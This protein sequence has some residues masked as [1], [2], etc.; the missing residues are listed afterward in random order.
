MKLRI[1]IASLIF[2]FPAMLSA[3]SPVISGIVKESGETGQPIAGANVYWAG[4]QTGTSTDAEGKFQLSKPEQYKLLVISF[5]G[6]KT[7]TVKVAPGL[8]NL[9]IE[10][11][12][13]LELGEVTVKERRKGIYYS[14]LNP[15]QV[16]KITTSELQ[17][18]AC[19]N[20]SESF[21]T[22]ASVDVAY[23]DAVTG[24]KQIQML[25]LAGTYVQTLGEAM[26]SVRGMA[27]GY[28]LG[29]VPGPWMESIQISKGT[30]SVVNGYEAITGQINVEYKKPDSEERF[31]FNLFASDE[32]KV[33][34]NLN[35]SVNLGEHLS[36]Q[37]LLH[38]ENHSKEI[39]DNGD[40]FLDLPHIRQ[41]NFMNRW[42]FHNHE[43]RHRQIGFK[44]LDENRRAGQVGAINNPAGNLYGIEIGTRRYELFAKN[45]YLF[46][47]PGHSLGMQFSASYHNQ[48]A[49]YGKNPYS[50]TQYTGYFNLIYEGNFGSEIHKYSTGVS[51]NADHYEQVLKNKNRITAEVVP[52]A[53]FQYTLGLHDRVSLIAGLRADYSTLHGLFFTPRVHSRINIT[54]WLVFRASAGKGYRTSLPLAESNYLLA[55]SRNLIIDQDL[56][57]EEAWNYGANLSG[58]IPLAGRELT[59]S[60]DYYRTSFINQV[61]RDLDSDAHAV[62]F[63]NLEGAS[64]S[65][66]AQAEIS[67]E[68]LKG[69][70][71][72]AAFRLN[73]ARQTINGTLDLLPLTHRYKGLFSVSYA[74]RLKKWQFDFTSQFNGGGRMP[75]PDQQN[76]LWEK[77]FDSFTL[78][79]AQVTR[80][81]KKW[82]FYLGSENLS[83]F[84]MDQPIIAASDPW[85]NQFDGSMIWGPVHGRKFYFG[86]RYTINKYK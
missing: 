58:H 63:M 68:L 2:L 76:P 20:L 1:Q 13:N 74:T 55:S 38:A 24:A 46:S 80:N 61:I 27:S 31:H 14:K 25:G 66:S 26:P 79:N 69:L 51:L 81:F 28:G 36:T 7:D 52:G 53:Y 37:I 70:N 84:T 34:A 33:E 60:L 18:A 15:I 71:I 73:D 19:C 22:N 3:N 78:F 85:G 50:G 65:N 16:Q 77:E 6:Y 9:E 54:D 82:S 86:L 23:S 32:E 40:L 4:T 49:I 83:N 72:N 11:N 35:A 5:V 10:L 42:E 21:E 43:G 8:D 47:K 57:Q 39:D 75:N 30:S 29:Y 48:E 41:I 45:G 12:P 67:Y 64:F 17:K 59:I 62:R 44:I 56:D